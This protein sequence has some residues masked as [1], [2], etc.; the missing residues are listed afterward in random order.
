MAILNLTAL[1]WLRN[2]FS[3]ISLSTPISSV[4]SPV[5]S[6][7]DRL[8]LAVELSS[9]CHKALLNPKAS[10]SIKQGEQ[11]SQYLGSGMEYEE[12]RPYQPG[13]EVRRI[14]WRLM[15]KTGQAYTKLFQEERQESWTILLDQRQSMRFGTQ[16]RLKVQQAIRVMGFYCWQAEKT[17]LPIEAISLSETV[18]SSPTY[19]GKGSFEHLMNFVSIP[20][21]PLQNIKESC[22]NDELLICQRRLQAGSK[23]IIIS[24]FSDMD[25]KTLTLLAALQ[26]KTMVKAILIYDVAEKKLPNITGLKLQSL[27]GGLEINASSQQHTYQQWSSQYFTGIKLKLAS[28]GV[29]VL[30][31]STI[32]ELTSLNEQQKAYA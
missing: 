29:R 12:S 2:K 14:N 23:L 4:Y 15:A 1:N 22:L 11:A 28:V 3:T 13:D 20:C 21:P 19:E 25:E 24:D 31:L 9:M 8:E 30:E 16:Q 7:E 17:G 5:F 6:V 10:E 18:K 27:N 26:D 32:D